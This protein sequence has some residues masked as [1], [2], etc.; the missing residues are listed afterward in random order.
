MDESQGVNNDDLSGPDQLPR[1][2][3]K[4]SD[5][6]DS[7]STVDASQS[8]APLGDLNQPLHDGSQQTPVDVEVVK[9]IKVL[10]KKGKK[11]YYCNFSDG[12]NMY[13]EYENRECIPQALRDDFHSKYTWKNK[14]KSK[15]KAKISRI[16][17][18]Q[19]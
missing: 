4:R 16:Y 18:I 14:L 6:G 2:L 11:W 17:K 9:I 1:C 12:K 3:R 8:Q 10:V 7:Q 5:S 19:R 15:P 13:I